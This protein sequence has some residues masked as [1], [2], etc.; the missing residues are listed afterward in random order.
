MNRKIRA[1]AACLLIIS[2]LTACGESAQQPEATAP[3]DSAAGTLPGTE[4]GVRDAADDVFSL[5]YNS[6]LSLNPYATTDNK[7]L[8]VTQLVCDNVFELDDDYNL[9]SRIVTNWTVSAEGTWWT[10]TID[11][12]IPMHDGSTL[13]AADVAYSIQLARNSARY[14]GRFSNLYGVSSSGDDTVNISTAKPDLQLL[15][16]LTVPVIKYGSYSSSRPAASGP[17]M[18]VEGED[19][20]QAFD[21]YAGE[22][23]LPVDRVYLKEYTETEEII[24]A[25]EDSYIDL[26]VND[27]SGKSNLGYGGNT[28]T[29]YFTT[30][31]MHYLGFNMSTPFLSYQ[32]FRYALQL[33]VDREYAAETLMNGGAVAS[34]LPVSPR[35]PLY[36]S[37]LASELQY[38]LEQPARLLD[39]TS[40]A[41]QDNDG[42]R[43]YIDMSAIQEIELDLIV[44]SES[45][46]KG[47]IAKQFS[48]DLASIG[49]MVNVRELSWNDYL[50][51]LQTGDFDIYY[52]EVKLPA[53]FD[54]TNLLT[55]EA[56]LNYGG[57]DD[58]NYATYINS[59]LAAGDTGRAQ[60]CYEMLRYIATNAP[61]V[62][63]CFERQQVITHRN[64]ITGINPTSSN[65]FFGISD[66]EINF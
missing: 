59:Y 3:V 28:E 8:L 40:V 58:E 55:Q 4:L 5:N 50:Y 31:N 51:A 38:D 61:I 62:P 10:L 9:T 33:A 7:N 57:I 43:E 19:Y 66:W 12:S 27:V 17:Y 41:D 24:T 11:T 53:N 22:G 32:Q 63:I 29:R 21:G 56:G 44:C 60:A 23:A 52:A 30:T 48:D 25:F 26:V 34:S 20:L 39:R 46:G 49:I 65:V 47:D 14:S 16:L 36:D 6:S 54:L 13:T 42:W 35:S 2:L 18:Y 45:A 64:A 15:Y 37:S 1:I